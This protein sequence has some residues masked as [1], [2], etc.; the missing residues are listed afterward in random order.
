MNDRD[1]RH[2]PVVENL[3][4]WREG[5]GEGELDEGEREFVALLV[6]APATPEATR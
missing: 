2:V 3:R 4:H 5:L 6:D 1:I